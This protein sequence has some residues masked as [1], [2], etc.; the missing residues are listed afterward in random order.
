MKSE[1]IETIVNK[2]LEAWPRHD[3]AALVACFA[4]DA[5]YTSMLV[6]TIHGPKAIEALYQS[7]FRAFPDMGFQ[8][9]S[10]LIHRNQAAILWSQSGTHMGELCGLPGSGRIFVLPGSFFMTFRE[11]RI[12]SMRSIY[13]F[14]GLLV[15]IGILK[16]K[17]AE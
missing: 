17:P 2:W 5:V 7:W 6:G 8:V 9:E 15:Q 10:R 13:D 1:K 16:A 3:A 12:V 4:D 14:T 11:G